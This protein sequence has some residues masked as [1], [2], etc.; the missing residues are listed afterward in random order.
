MLDAESLIFD[1]PKNKNLIEHVGDGRQDNGANAWSESNNGVTNR[2]EV[3]RKVL[4]TPVP[5]T[6]H[7]RTKTEE[8]GSGERR[9]SLVDVRAMPWF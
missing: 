1:I 4:G 8:E 7:Q 6:S 2:I 5:W 3:R 9:G